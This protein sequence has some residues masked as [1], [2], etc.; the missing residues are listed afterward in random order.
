MPVGESREQFE[1]RY[2]KSYPYAVF[3][4]NVVS[5]ACTCED[6]G[7]PTH[8]AAVPNTD[9]AIREHEAHEECLKWLREH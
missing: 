7:G 8:W 6:G 4:K 5:L 1:A 9:D 2:C 3:G